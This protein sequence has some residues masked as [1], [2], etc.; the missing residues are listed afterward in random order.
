MHMV[1]RND[2]IRPCF[3]GGQIGVDEYIV[4][5]LDFDRTMNAFFVERKKPWTVWN[6]K[7]ANAS[8]SKEYERRSERYPI[9]FHM[10]TLL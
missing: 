10:K 9:S 7:N 5:N 8:S 1:D 4:Q 6:R 2:V 3:Q